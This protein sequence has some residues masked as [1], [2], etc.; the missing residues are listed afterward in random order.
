MYFLADFLFDGNQ[1]ISNAFVE[2][3]TDGRI[4]AVGQVDELK[5]NTNILSKIGWFA[6]ARLCKH[7]LPP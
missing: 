5:D 4:L 2:V 7:P 3:D 1:I 6:Y